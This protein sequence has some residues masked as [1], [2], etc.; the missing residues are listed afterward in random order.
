[1]V[2][3]RSMDPTLH[4][5]DR[6][7]IRYGAAPRPGRV[8]VVKLPNRPGLS[9]KRIGWPDSDGWWIERDNPTEG[10]DS[11]QT[12][13]VRADAVVAIALCRVWTRPRLLPRP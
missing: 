9:V 2:R 1:V 6:L 3:G 5:G 12:G 7:L 8:V 13:P 10:V 4:D 11:W